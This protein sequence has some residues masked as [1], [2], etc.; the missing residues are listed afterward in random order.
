MTDLA[1]IINTMKDLSVLTGDNCISVVVKS[2]TEDFV[3]VAFENLFTLP[4]LRVPQPSSLVNARCQHL[5]ALRVEAYLQTSH[6]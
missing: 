2:A 5:R 1:V 4:R 3:S 6:T